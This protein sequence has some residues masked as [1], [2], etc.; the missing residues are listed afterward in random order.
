MRPSEP[1]QISVMQNHRP[2][3]PRCGAFTSLVCIEPASEPDHDLRT[4]ECSACG[5]DEVVKLKFR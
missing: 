5:H 4:F 1:A 2:P 3:C